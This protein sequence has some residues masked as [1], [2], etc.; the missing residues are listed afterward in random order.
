MYTFIKLKEKDRILLFNSIKKN[1]N[2]SWE[3]FY[4]SLN[5]SRP[6]FFH[7][8]SGKHDIPKNIFL[9]LEK[10][11][12]IKIKTYKE[13]SK[14]KY[15]LKKIKTPKE[16]ASLAEIFGILNGDGHL[17]P[18]NYEI[19]VVGNL[20][21]EDY[22][23]YLKKLFEN[24]FS[25]K[26]TI[27]RYATHLKLRIYSK[28]LFNLLSKKYGLPKGN[29]MGKLFIPKKVFTHKK[30]LVSYIRGLFDTDGSFY[31]RRK[32]EPVVQI[33]SADDIFLEEIK[34]ALMSLNFNVAKG[35]NRVFIYKKEDIIK[36]Y[37]LIKPA[38]SKHLKKFEIYSS[39]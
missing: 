26:F 3:N 18:I 5:I 27:N 1:I 6:M 36:F 39:S 25:L 35:V 9:K 11:S 33:T 7:Y 19:C 24:T 28:N 15:F 21:E 31:F 16:N 30:W 17:S 14:N 34:G 22:F 20:S 13:I 2:S 29:K 23:L 8:L 38:N 32:K 37:N 12:K 4:P 10:K